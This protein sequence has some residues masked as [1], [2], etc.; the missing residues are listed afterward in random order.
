MFFK[1]RGNGARK[2]VLFT[3]TYKHVEFLITP[4][5]CTEFETLLLSVCDLFMS[6]YRRYPVSA[7]WLLYVPPGFNVHKIVRSAHAVYL[8]VLYGSQNKQRLLYY[9]ALTDWFF[10]T[11]RK[12]VFTARYGL[13]LCR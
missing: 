11:E 12:S 6:S 4:R 5:L 13:Y 8:C 3:H 1:G 2:D 9:T 10:I 7:Q